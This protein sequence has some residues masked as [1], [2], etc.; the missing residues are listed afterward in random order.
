V[1]AD[2]Y[3]RLAYPGYAYPATHPARLEAIARLFGLSPT[4]AAQARVLELGC[5]DGGNALSLA[6]ALPG[7]SL[8][9]IDL[10]AGAIARGQRLAQAA[11][12]PNVELRTGNLEELPHMDLSTPSQP[13]ARAEPSDAIGPKASDM[14]GF[15]YVIAHGV[16]SWIPP[17]ARVGLLAGIHRHM[18]PEGVAF[19]SYNAYPGSYLR[20]MARDILAYHAREEGDPAQKL[21]RAQ[22]LMRTI[23]AIEEP[24]PYAQVLREHMGRMLRYSDAL[25]FHDDLAEV[26]TPFYFSEFMEHATHHRLA[27][28]SEAD[29]FESQMR[30]VPE[31]AGRLMEE[32][33]DDVVV[34]EQ[35]L[36]FFKN[37][38][39]RQTLLCHAQAPVR[40]ELQEP[41]IERFAVS[42]QARAQERPAAGGTST[43]AEE[44]L[45]AVEPSAAGES[46]SVTFA[47][48]EGYSMTTSEP[49]VHAAM[50]A[51]T[52]VWPEAVDFPTLLERATAAAGPQAPQE[53]V[54]AR[55]R[56]VLL[57]AYLARIVVLQGC[58]PPLSARP[59]ERPLASPLARAQCVAGSRTVSSLLHANARLEGKLE[60]Q[61]LT[62]LDGTRDREDLHKELS[63]AGRA[64][65]G[66]AELDGAL[67]RLASLGLLIDNPAQRAT[68][69]A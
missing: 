48:P 61:L 55:L 39:F 58:P 66:L 31:S 59:G 32:L 47:T 15:D 69:P 21:A 50:E 64:P 35:Y 49:L 25:L 6:Q 10:A 16:Y 13:Q 51:L 56:A 1:S 14:G 36:D 3:D 18:A 5:G 29:L 65:L 54:A 9:G 33:P 24:S 19:V 38:V 63:A 52:Q 41:Q 68:G 40:R 60:P 7:A 34:R 53:L 37:R 26:S 20:D 11:G 43:A 57:Q 44:L 46:P 67:E 28:L 2:P 4:P 30:N 27:F 42:S 17:R 12:L 22:E 62:L 45:P 8:V 23:V